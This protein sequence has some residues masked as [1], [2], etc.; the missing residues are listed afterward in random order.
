MAAL[1]RRAVVRAACLVLG[2]FALVNLFFYGAAGV[3]DSLWSQ[4][5]LAALWERD[6][7]IGV[8]ADLSLTE[9]QCRATFPGLMKEIDDAVAR[10]PFHLKKEPDDYTGMVQLRITDGKV[11]FII[12]S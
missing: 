4:N 12:L 7:A 6:P 11:S 5:L 8:L 9:R 1:R 10:G 2:L 3:A